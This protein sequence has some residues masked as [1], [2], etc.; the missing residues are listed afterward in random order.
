MLQLIIINLFMKLGGAGLVLMEKVILQ[1]HQELAD[2]IA[3][4]VLGHSQLKIYFS[5]S[6]SLGSLVHSPMDSAFS[7]YVV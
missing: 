4:L 2:L 6:R 1:W 3:L 7:S 5:K